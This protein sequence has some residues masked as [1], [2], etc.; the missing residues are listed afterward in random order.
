MII[1]NQE[2]L[3]KFIATVFNVDASVTHSRQWLNLND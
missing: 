2:S 3:E 1:K